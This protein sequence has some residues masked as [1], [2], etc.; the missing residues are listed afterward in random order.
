[1]IS[2]PIVNLNVSF[3]CDLNVNREYVLLLDPAP[4]ADID[5]ATTGS[6]NMNTEPISNISDKNKKPA[7]PSANKELQAQN[8]DLQHADLPASALKKSNKKKKTSAATLTSVNEKLKEAYTGKQKPVAMHESSAAIENKT[9]SSSSNHNQSKDKPFLVISG[10]NANLNESSN[11]PSLTLRLATEIDF[12][13]PEA[14]IVPPTTTD[15]MD[16]ATVMT[17]RLAHLE[18]QIANLQIRNTQLVADAA[19]AKEE[20]E[21]FDWRQMLLIALGIIVALA[22]AE[23]LRR[24]IFNKRANNETAEWFD[25][26]A[27]IDTP[28][29]PTMLSSNGFEAARSDIQPF[30]EP[31]PVTSPSQHSSLTNKVSALKF[32]EEDHGS[33]LDDADV[34]IEHG[35]PVLA[36]QLLQN[37]LID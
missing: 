36:I 21:Y 13:R 17:N 15:A 20:K 12:T 25:A 9:P 31:N 37:H 32:E 22:V 26:E 1:V 16:E 30:G 8:A 35:R 24:K 28:N 11:K 27:T 23:W 3:H 29:E 18:K 7:H 34:F 4:L 10:G 6:E 33:I 19:K 14:A 5:N 2:E